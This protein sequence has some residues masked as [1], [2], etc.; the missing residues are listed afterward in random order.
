[1]DK[2]KK[3]PDAEFEI[4]KVVWANE[5]P[6]TTNIIMQQLGNEREWR[7]QTAISLLMRLVGRGFLRTEKNSKERMYFPVV[8]KEDYLIFE[9]SNFIRQFHENSFISLVT[10]MY[11]DKAL[12]DEELD[13]LFNWVKKRK[14]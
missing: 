6:I 7:P 14:E 12:T 4:M 1:M 8:N 2:M 10:A 9:T 3:L 11:G 13:E 5:P